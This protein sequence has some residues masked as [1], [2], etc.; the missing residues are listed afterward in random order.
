MTHYFFS[1]SERFWSPKNSRV[2][3]R[4]V[5]YIEQPQVPLEGARRLDA[6]AEACPRVQLNPS[7]GGS[8]YM[9]TQAFGTCCRAAATGPA[10]VASMGHFFAAGGRHIDTADMYGNHR[11]VAAGLRKFLAANGTSR[12]ELF[13]TSK[14]WTPTLRGSGAQAVVAAVDRFLDELGLSYLDMVMLHKPICPGVDKKTKGPRLASCLKALWRGLTEAQRAGKA[15]AIGVSNFATQ[16]I[17]PLLQAGLPVP[18]V[19]QIEYHPFVGASVRATAAWCRRN[20]I[21]ISAHSP[22]GSSKMAAD[23]SHLSNKLQQVAHAH[24]LTGVQ[25]LLRSS[26]DENVSVVPGA[27]SR[28]H[29]EENLASCDAQFSLTPAERR[30]LSK[31]AKPQGW[32]RG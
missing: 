19:N 24:R 13:V 11:D 10:L 27:T 1:G 29:I 21:A 4:F 31:E 6:H 17:E 3:Q 14:V 32:Q 20:G 7:G 26:L 2:A 12:E 22:L 23:R 28:A 18:A 16:H 30:A 25:V 5:H 9:P 8:S 15:R